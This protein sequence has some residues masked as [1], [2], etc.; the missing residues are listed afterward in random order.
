MLE[1]VIR[2]LYHLAR[3]E[4][5]CES[6]K[7]LKKILELLTDR[8]V[9][10]YF[11]EIVL[12]TRTFFE[13]VSEP[14]QESSLPR[15]SEWTERGSGSACSRP[16]ILTNIPFHSLPLLSILLPGL[17]SHINPLH[18][19]PYPMFSVGGK[20]MMT[21]LITGLDVNASNTIFF[22]CKISKIQNACV[23]HFIQELLNFPMAHGPNFTPN[24]FLQV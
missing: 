1:S 23:V 2:G 17:T 22:M 6:L 19:N 9:S 15:R 20:Q 4:V 7:A 12:Q 14:D 18:L 24:I 3:T 13:D 21:V 5:V 8:D 11:K 10:F 16:A